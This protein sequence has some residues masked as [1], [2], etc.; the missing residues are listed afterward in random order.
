[1]II[2]KKL[3]QKMKSKHLNTVLPNNK[4]GSCSTERIFGMALYQEGYK[5]FIDFLDLLDFL[6]ILTNPNKLLR[7]RMC[8]INFLIRFYT[9]E[10]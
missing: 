7:M 1:M 8:A 3:L 2:S 6:D 4:I 9:L 10:Y 5:N